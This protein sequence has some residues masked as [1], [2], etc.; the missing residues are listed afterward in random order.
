[1]GKSHHRVLVSQV[2]APTQGL[3]KTFERVYAEGDLLS[4][5][6]YINQHS[7][8]HQNTEQPLP[9]SELP[10][11]SAAQPLPLGNPFWPSSPF[12][13]QYDKDATRCVH[14]GPWQI[15]PAL[16]VSKDKEESF[17]RRA[18]CTALC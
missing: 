11:H 13:D 14:T 12:E 10:Q 7:H 2:S 8:V 18:G 5:P 4:T 9:A 17:P 6:D 1:M 15:L 3:R 16:R